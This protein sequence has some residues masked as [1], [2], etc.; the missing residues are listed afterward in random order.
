LRSSGVI[1]AD[2][3]LFDFKVR[4]ASCWT[5]RRGQPLISVTCKQIIIEIRFG[6]CSINHKMNSKLPNIGLGAD[7]AKNAEQQRY[8]TAVTWRHL[9]LW[10]FVVVR[11]LFGPAGLWQ[12]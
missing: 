6:N 10:S 7:Y 3:C 4:S 5:S 2:A 9:E 1:E 11:I 8:V 12:G